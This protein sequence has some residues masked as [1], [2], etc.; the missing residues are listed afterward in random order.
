MISKDDIIKAKKKK[1]GMIFPKS[2]ALYFFEIILYSFTWL[3]W[4]GLSWG[5]QDP[6]GITQA[7][8]LVAHGFWFWHVGLVAPRHVGS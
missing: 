7:L 1:K 6:R 5:T 8:F 4:S 3:C 2:Q